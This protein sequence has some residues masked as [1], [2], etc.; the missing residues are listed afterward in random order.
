VEEIL[1]REIVDE[2]DR[3][4]ELAS[5]VHAHTT[6][7]LHPIHTA[8][9]VTAPSHACPKKKQHNHTTHH[10]PITHTH[11]TSLSCTTPHITT[12]PSHTHTYTHTHA[13]IPHTHPSPPHHTL[14]IT[15]LH[16]AYHFPITHTIPHLTSLSHN[17]HTVD[18]RTLKPRERKHVEIGDFVD[19]S[20]SDTPIL[21][22]QQQL[23]I[24]QFLSTGG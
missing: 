20:P 8:Q 6:I 14:H 1:Q 2:T 24:Y 17:P 23:A 3:I 15:S 5:C 21:S 19:P 22:S 16:T 18:N 12:A 10:L 13:H 9:H 7:P 11:I 4:S